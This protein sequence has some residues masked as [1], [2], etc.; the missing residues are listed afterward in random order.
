MELA[1][2]LIAALV[3]KSTTIIAIAICFQVDRAM[4]QQL[5]NIHQIPKA[6]EIGRIFLRGGSHSQTRCI[7]SIQIGFD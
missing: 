4:R 6:T 7:E 5:V 1:R 2:L 3:V